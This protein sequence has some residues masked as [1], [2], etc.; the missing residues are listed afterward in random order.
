MNIPWTAWDLDP[1]TVIPLALSAILYLRGARQSRGVTAAQ[2]ACFWSGW[3]MLG[4]ALL[5]PIAALD[6]QLFSAHMLQHEILMLM[7][8]PL[9]VLSRPVAAFLWGL[10]FRWRRKAGAWAK[11]P[12][13]AKSWRAITLPLIAW[14]LHAAAIWIW[15]APALFQATLTSDAVH[16]AQHA[17]FLGTA[18]LFWW[19]LFH[20]HRNMHYGSGVLYVFTTA[21]HTS[22]LG[23][24][25]TFAPRIWYP[26]YATTT[27]AWGLTPLED[28]QIGGLIMWVPAGVVYL[29][30]GLALFAAWLRESDARTARLAMK[31]ST[32]L[33]L[34]IFV[35]SCRTQARRNADAVTGGSA[36]RG[37]TAISHYG[38]GSCHTIQGIVGA[39]GL[40]GPPLTGVGDRLYVAGVLPN[41][42]Q[43]MAH[44]IRH[45]TQID[46]KTVMPELG[47]TDRDALD[48]T[49]YLYSLP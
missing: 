22:I 26:A 2:M 10:P 43:N 37:A 23:A 5:S 6:E 20:V 21:V 42:P 27:S 14:S 29:G 11:L 41:S 1:G 8:A 36:M 39:S 40:V 44:W 19:S 30:A 9:L 47:V 46:E 31:V 34:A 24:L 17:S 4:L 32:L 18:L 3:A 33:L 28:Q 48:I 38:C 25:L 45:P 49:A 15:H 13:F 7:A 12:W 16:A 35:S